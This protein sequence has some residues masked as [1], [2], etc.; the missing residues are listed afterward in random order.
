MP[1]VIDLTGRRPRRIPAQPGIIDLTG[2][3]AHAMLQAGDI[4]NPPMYGP[5]LPSARLGGHRF[6]GSTALDILAKRRLP[7]R[8]H[9]THLAPLPRA[10]PPGAPAPQKAPAPYRFPKRAI[11]GGGRA[12]KKITKNQLH[13]RGE[14]YVYKSRRKKRYFDSAGSYS[15]ASDKKKKKKRAEESSESSTKT[16]KKT[17]KKRR[18]RTKRVSAEQRAY[19]PDALVSASKQRHTDG[20]TRKVGRRTLHARRSRTTADLIKIASALRQSAEERLRAISAS[21]HRDER[22]RARARW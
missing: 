17:K 18:R 9:T 6:T 8:P 1:S 4:S 19:G 21:I 14:H 5:T 20:G 16:E 3:P 2:A 15:L 11:G 10:T 13:G 22:A 12:G 7:P